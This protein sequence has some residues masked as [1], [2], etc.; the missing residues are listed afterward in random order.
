MSQRCGFCHSYGHTKMGCPHAK[1]LVEEHME[2]YKTARSENPDI[3]LWDIR[4]KHGWTWK[5]E[6]A[7]ELYEK[8]KARAKKPRT[9]NFCGES[10]HNKRS[11]SS[12]KR[13]IGYLQEANVAYRKELLKFLQKNGVGVGS[14]IQRKYICTWNSSQRGWSEAHNVVCMVTGIDWRQLGIYGYRA[15][16]SL[17]MPQLDSM[18]C[19]YPS[20][21]LK[22]RGH[23]PFVQEGIEH[24]CRGLTE[25]NR[26]YKLL[27]PAPVLPPD[28]WIDGSDVADALTK[29]MKHKDE[30]SYQWLEWERGY[31]YK[32]LLKWSESFR[33]EVANA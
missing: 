29:A 20:I 12:L 13:A 15:P 17:E 11:C 23:I 28:N 30:N 2:E 7:F 16:L 19:Y 10:G 18:G 31:K 24:P 6:E 33:K 14:I 22:D 27:T 25:A 5:V 1:K 32:M 3:S 4:H 9:C 21:N 8:K 26:H